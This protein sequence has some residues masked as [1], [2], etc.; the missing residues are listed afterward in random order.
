MLVSRTNIVVLLGVIDEDLGG[1]ASRAGVV[2]LRAAFAQAANIVHPQFRHG[3][4]ASAVGVIFIGQ[5]LPWL[6]AQARRDALPPR[7]PL[8]AVIGRLH[9]LHVHDQRLCPIRGNLHALVGGGAPRPP[10]PPARLRFRF[11]PPPPR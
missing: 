9:H 5:H 1:E 6:A 8:F 2:F 10:P 11:P 7:R 3:L 4:D